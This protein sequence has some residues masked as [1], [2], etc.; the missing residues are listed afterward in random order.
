MKKFELQPFDYENLTEAV[1]VHNKALEQAKQKLRETPGL[2]SGD[3]E[4][5]LGVLDGLRRDVHSEV[6][7]GIIKTYVMGEATITYGKLL[8]C[9]N[10]ILNRMARMGLIPTNGSL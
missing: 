5:A 4:F 9:S 10:E 8:E 1:N 2:P 3:I 6:I 7:A